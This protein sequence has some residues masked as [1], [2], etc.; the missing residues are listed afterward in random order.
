MPSLIITRLT[1][2][3][4]NIVQRFSVKVFGGSAIFG[5]CDCKSGL[6]NFCLYTG[7]YRVF[8]LFFFK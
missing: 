1:R 6:R 8:I 7:Y 3:F 5:F 4:K 2:L